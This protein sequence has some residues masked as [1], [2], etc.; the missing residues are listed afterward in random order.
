MK[1]QN[2]GRKTRICELL[3]FNS[4]Y[5]FAV[6]LFRKVNQLDRQA[7]T[8]MFDNS[9]TVAKVTAASAAVPSAAA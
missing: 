1:L 9:A 4:E 5:V 2:N 3:G 7:A 6:Q 8:A